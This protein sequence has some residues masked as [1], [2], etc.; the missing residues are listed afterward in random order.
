MPSTRR[1]PRGAPAP[2]G[3]PLY[4]A[5]TSCNCSAWEGAEPGTVV[6]EHI[7]PPLITPTR[8]V[9]TQR[10]RQTLKPQQAPRPNLLALQVSRVTPQ[11]RARASGTSRAAWCLVLGRARTGCAP[12]LDSRPRALQTAGPRTRPRQ[13]PS[14]CNP[15][16]GPR[17]APRG[18]QQHLHA[19]TAPGSHNV[20]QW[21]G[22]DDEA[23][24]LCSS[25]YR[26]TAWRAAAAPG[27]PVCRP[28]W[29]EEQAAAQ[30]TWSAE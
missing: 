19:G 3:T 16:H 15:V 21:E 14:P 27:S 2:G 9:T 25:E 30:A 28:Q 29:H 13:M 10:M 5:R 24:P 22:V 1:S 7:H 20:E 26:A 6:E 17:A 18:S 23:Q 4:A 8:A 12:L 11:V